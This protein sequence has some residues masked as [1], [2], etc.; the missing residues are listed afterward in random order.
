MRSWNTIPLCS[1]I[2]S[3]DTT[4]PE[5]CESNIQEEDIPLYLPGGWTIFGFTCI[6]SMDVVDAFESIVNEVHKKNR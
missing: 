6:E 3:I 1:D 4:S 5:D 2:N